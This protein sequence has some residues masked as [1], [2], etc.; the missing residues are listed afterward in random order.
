[1]KKFNLTAICLITLLFI[2]C[3]DESHGKGHK[4]KRGDKSSQTTETPATPVE[5]VHLKTGDIG[6]YI[7]L[8]STIDTEQM[9][10]VYAQASGF[11]NTILK[12]EGSFVEKGEALVSLDAREAK[13]RFERA[14]ATFEKRKNEY[15]RLKQN[16]DK[17]VL[18]KEEIENIKYQYDIARIEKAEA[19]LALD[20][21]TIK[22]PIDGIVSQ[23]EV[24]LG[25]RVD[26][27][28]K[29]YTVTNVNELITVVN[30]PEKEMGRVKKGQYV[31]L[32]SDNI[33]DAG[34]E[35]I[36]FPAKVKRVAPVINP[37]SGTYKVTVA[38][39]PDRRLYAG[40]FI[41]VHIRTDLHKNS[42]L[43]PKSAL[44]YEN[45][46]KYV[47]AV[48]DSL[49]E[50]INIEPG[51]EDSYFIETNSTRLSNGDSVVLLGKEGLKDAAKVKVVQRQTTSE[52]ASRK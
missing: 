23:R 9:I 11:V 10:D 38:V 47:F 49:V 42:L 14:K 31:E 44:V 24:K 34:G 4:G 36:R 26:I 8:S 5:T 20:Y 37:L 48:R 16:A 27:G 50:K 19:E 1:M 39:T 15:D 21:A 45:E 13:L 6:S 52:V 25:D 35:V 3:S 41:N 29:V 33:R 17:S 7:L 46:Q 2:S 30:V 51:Y 12:E 32:F 22:S 28:K 40:A 43:V 18:S